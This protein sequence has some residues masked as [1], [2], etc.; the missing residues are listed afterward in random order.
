MLNVGVLTKGKSREFR[1]LEAFGDFFRSFSEIPI[2]FDRLF[3]SDCSLSALS[4][5]KTGV[6]CHSR[7]RVNDEPKINV[8]QSISVRF[9]FSCRGKPGLRVFKFRSLLFAFVAI[10]FQR[11]VAAE[12]GG[13]EASGG[14]L[15]SRGGPETRRTVAENAAIPVGGHAG[16]TDVRHHEADGNEKNPDGGDGDTEN[17]EAEYASMIRL[18]AS[19]KFA[20]RRSAMDDLRNAGMA[21]V[22]SLKL[23]RTEGELEFR[24]RVETLIR[25]IQED[26]YRRHF[27][28][29]QQLRTAEQAAYFPEWDRYAVVV[30]SHAEDI[31]N[32]IRI[33]SAEPILMA[34]AIHDRQSLP[35]AIE[36]RLN[37]LVGEFHNSTGSRFPVESFSALLLLCSNEQLRLRGAT[38]AMLSSALSDERLLQ[39]FRGG[40][41]GKQ[42]DQRENRDRTPLEFLIGR[43]ILRRGIAV[44]RPLVFVM[45]TRIPEGRELAQRIIRSKTKR[46]EMMLAM[47]ALAVFRNAGDI[48]LLESQFDN[49]AVLW[50]PRAGMRPAPNQERDGGIESRGQTRGQGYRV[51]TRDIALAV[52]IHLREQ[53]P[54]LFGFMAHRV[55]STV[56]AGSSLG[57]A[58]DHVR[59]T[60]LE[61]YRQAFP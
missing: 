17:S 61:R 36:M 21:A 57:F 6:L 11:P 43:W 50:P 59:Q 14:E 18:L 48:S 35:A 39:M 53:E 54:E 44:E 23:V 34:L 22:P 9:L 52:A 38:S 30:G 51:E 42:E 49:K 7:L 33:I 31:Q 29:L 60:A 20:E 12:S 28:E 8:F 19:E 15:N 16:L 55:E 2:G 56:F 46:P 27:H 32:Y 24:E 3:V 25:R 26:D 1:S 10:L 47:L 4:G 40:N 58:D 13:V 37:Q 41:A 5:L 45:A